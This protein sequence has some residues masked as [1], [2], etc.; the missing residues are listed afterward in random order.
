M[1][2]NGSFV[3]LRD[4]DFIGNYRVARFTAD[5]AAATNAIENCR[6]LD[7]S[8]GALYIT[9][10]T[11]AFNV[12]RCEIAR[13]YIYEDSNPA[14][15]VRLSDCVVSSNRTCTNPGGNSNVTLDVNTRSSATQNIVFERCDFVGNIGEKTRAVLISSTGALA[16][17]IQFRDCLFARNDLAVP[18][19]GNP[20]IGGIIYNTASSV[21]TFVNCLFEKNHVYAPAGAGV[22]L[23]NDGW[24][25]SVFLHCTFAG[26]AISA[27]DPDRAADF[28]I[29]ES[30]GSKTHTLANCV[31]DEAASG[32]W[33]IRA[34]GGSVNLWC[35]FTRGQATNDFGAAKFDIQGH[36]SAN[37]LVHASSTSGSNGRI[38]RP[39]SALTPA[40]TGMPVQRA[41]DGNYYVFQAWKAEGN[42]AKPWTAP[43]IKD[44]TVAQAEALDLSLGRDS[45]PDAWGQPR[46]AG[47]PFYCG[48]LNATKAG[49]RFILR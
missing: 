20:P 23:C 5:S 27:D 37:P 39:L 17:S 40:G 21:M 18:Q 48:H 26:N 34:N 28:C 32:H 9:A 36:S 6:F 43:N 45:I 11:G 41:T 1:Q 25:N 31:F 42:N 30:S 46:P 22:I 12:V 14:C 47:K 44:F 49:F 4:C 19:G 8:G 13:N 24:R 33:P 16:G 10:S 15:A 29:L 2:V 35:V 7:N 3:T 38:G